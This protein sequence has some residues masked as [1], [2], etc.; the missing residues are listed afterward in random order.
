MWAMLLATKYNEEKCYLL[1]T[2]EADIN[3]NINKKGNKKTI[4][5]Y[6]S[7]IKSQVSRKSDGVRYG[8]KHVI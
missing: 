6:L 2:Y 4:K 5:N 7:R 8:I 3:K 1:Q